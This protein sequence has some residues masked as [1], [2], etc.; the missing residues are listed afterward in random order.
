MGMARCFQLRTGS[1]FR[2]IAG[3]HYPWLFSWICTRSNCM[4]LG[5]DGQPCTQAICVWGSITFEQLWSL[6][7]CHWTDWM[8]EAN[9]KYLVVPT[10]EIH[11]DLDTHECDAGCVLCT[12]SCIACE[13]GAHT[14]RLQVPL[15]V[16]GTQSTF[17][18]TKSYGTAVPCSSVW[19]NLKK[20]YLHSF[21]FVLVILAAHWTG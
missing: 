3:W 16:N 18:A 7:A 12:I 21:F 17:A 11:M 4:W 20:Y 6:S 19:H 14:R 8:A 5:T 1:M 10:T 9:S 13:C 2:S 15:I